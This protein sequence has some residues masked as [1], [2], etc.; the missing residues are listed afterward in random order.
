M[1]VFDLDEVSERTVPGKKALPDYRPANF[2]YKNHKPK[3]QTD[4]VSKRVV[5]PLPLGRVVDTY[6][7]A[8]MRECF[9]RHIAQLPLGKAMQF[10]EGYEAKHGAQAAARLSSDI[11]A[12]EAKGYL[13][14]MD[15]AL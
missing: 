2:R 14:E 8:W 6:S 10:V 13:S 11:A 7:Q 15:L 9:A 3:K 12:I 1:S 5:P 4:D